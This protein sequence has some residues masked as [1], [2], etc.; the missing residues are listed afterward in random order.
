[1]ATIDPDD[2]GGC[3]DK[4]TCNGNG[5]SL[6]R[7]LKVEKIGELTGSGILCFDGF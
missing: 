5:F 7:R 4:S 3:P 6:A 2:S 1:M